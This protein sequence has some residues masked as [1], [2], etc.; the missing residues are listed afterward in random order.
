PTGDE[1]ARVRAQSAFE[2]LLDAAI[3]L[4]GTVTG[5]H[6]VGLLKRAGMV[7]ELDPGSLVLQRSIKAALDPL[8]V[9]NPGKVL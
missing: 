5:E 3:T 7:R 8:G 4:G 2:Q 9:F 6:G 1:V